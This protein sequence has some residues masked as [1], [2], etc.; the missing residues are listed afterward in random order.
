MLWII[1]DTCVENEESVESVE[2]E[3]KVKRCGKR[4]KSGKSV[5]NEESE[6]WTQV[7]QIRW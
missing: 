3:W 5:E 7:E 1:V 4:D 2:N 6:N